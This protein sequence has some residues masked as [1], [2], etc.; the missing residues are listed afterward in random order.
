MFTVSWEEMKDFINTKDAE[1]Q[2]L[3]MPNDYIVVARDS[4]FELRCFLT[5]ENPR[6]AEQVDFEDNFKSLAGKLDKP[7]KQSSFTAKEEGGK[8]LFTRTHGSTFTLAVGANDC[9]FTVPYPQV[10]FNA[11]EIVGCEKGDV[12]SL[13]ILD[14]DSGTVSTVPNYVLNQF[15]FSVGV[16]DGFYIRESKYDADLF[17]GLKVK[18]IYESVSAKD[19]TIN[20]VMHE[21]K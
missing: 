12:V 20:Y 16:P 8:K 21:L 10:K 4:W 5:K 7:V 19:V 14:D 2:F 1:F 15:G 18:V 6:N 17:Y 3:E 13:Q 9:V 11:L